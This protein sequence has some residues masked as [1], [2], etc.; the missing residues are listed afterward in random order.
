VGDSEPR[1]KLEAKS[2]K[3]TG[4]TGNRAIAIICSLVLEAV[5]I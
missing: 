3:E 4:L 2:R 1:A 5:P